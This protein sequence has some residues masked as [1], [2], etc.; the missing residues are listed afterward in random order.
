MLK[1]FQQKGLRANKYFAVM[2]GMVTV[3]GHAVLADTVYRCSEAY[4]TS[5]QCAKG[6]ATE[7][8]PAAILH[9][10]E[11]EK[12][13]A[14]TRDLRDAQA[15]EKNRLQAEHQA[16]QAAPIRL[17]TPSSPPAAPATSSVTNHEPL[18]NKRKGKHARKP[19]SPYF[20]A[21][22][23]SAQAKKK[24]TAKAVPA[25]SASNP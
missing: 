16:A 21:V 22:D 2:L 6:A 15:L 25:N 19:N 8:R 7:V 10:T 9:T 11:P 18:A 14:A 5:S 3:L 17:N 24:S 1:K 13:N 12:V 4:S 20:T 23:P